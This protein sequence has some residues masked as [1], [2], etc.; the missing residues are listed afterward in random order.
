M[1]LSKSDIFEA[2]TKVTDE[3]YI[4]ELTIKNKTNKE[5]DAK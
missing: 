3:L 5:K 4:Q 1:I 2:K